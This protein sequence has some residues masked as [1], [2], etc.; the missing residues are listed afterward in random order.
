[1]NEQRKLATGT[2]AEIKRKMKDISDL[3]ADFEG[4]VCLL[5]SENLAE[6]KRREKAE[7]EL[8]LCKRKLNSCLKQLKGEPLVAE[9]CPKVG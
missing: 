9:N 1:M 5:Q 4:K 7:V 3:R 8:D 6:A 2:A